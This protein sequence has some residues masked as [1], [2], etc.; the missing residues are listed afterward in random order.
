MTEPLPLAESASPATWRVAFGTRQGTI[1]GEP[2][3]WTRLELNLRVAS[4]CDAALTC[5]GHD[6]ALGLADELVSDMWVWLGDQLAFRGRITAVDDTLTTD[7]HSVALKATD[8][9]GVLARRVL[10]EGDQI[11]FVQV[12]QA[13]IAWK[14]IDQTQLHSG[15]GLGITRGLIPQSQPRD[16]Q[17]TPGQGV[18]ELLDNLSE[19]IGGFD[20]AVDP[21]LRLNVYY[22]ARGAEVP[23]VL[24]YGASVARMERRSSSAEFANVVRVAGAEG[25]TPKVSTAAGIATDPH[26]RWELNVSEPDLKLQSTV[27]DRAARFLA[28]RQSRPDV[29]D[30]TLTRGAWPTLGLRPGDWA[31]LRAACCRLD[32]L[33]RVRITEVAIDADPDGGET[34]KLAA[35]RDPA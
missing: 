5:S 12:P 14:L 9:R 23:A 13:E 34:V 35:V 8:Y 26:G 10:L 24:E 30:L 1:L 19:V 25:T 2:T 21:L 18:G 29:Y 28:D 6:I 16:R 17:Y 33:E 22:P 7:D 31:T 15:G 3:R 32:L 4:A 27:N 20:Y 11:N